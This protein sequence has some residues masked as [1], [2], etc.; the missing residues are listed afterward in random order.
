M[1]NIDSGN[2]LRT[3]LNAMVAAQQEHND[4]M[5]TD[6]RLFRTALAT[7][8]QKV[9]LFTKLLRRTGAIYS[10]MVAT[11][12]I[13]PPV[14]RSASTESALAAVD[15]AAEAALVADPVAEPKAEPKAQLVS[16]LV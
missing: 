6:A 1:H 7:E 14:R 12:A 10:S 16:I 4:G 2:M 5:A 9:A 13:P 15:S 8:K 11:G 3:E